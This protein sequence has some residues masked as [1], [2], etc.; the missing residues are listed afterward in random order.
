M[1]SRIDTR[2]GE[3]GPRRGPRQEEQRPGAD[4]AIAASLQQALAHHQ[5]GELARAELLYRAILAQQPNHVDSLHLL[6]VIEVQRRSFAAAVELIT[7]AI[8][9]DP[10]HSAF[11]SNLGMALQELKRHEDALAS[12]NRALAIKSDDAELLNSHGNV[13]RSLKRH[14][15]ALASYDRALEVRPD[16]VDALYN[17]GV[18]LQNLKRHEEALASYDHALAIKPDHAEAFYNRGN[19]LK[20]LSRHEEAL[21]SYERTLAIRPGYVEALNN[22]GNTLR[23]LKRYDEAVA[24][25][26]RALAIQPDYAG[27]LHN[28][29]T[30]LLEMRR[31]EDA[32]ESFA[33]LLEIAPDFDYALGNLF[34]SRLHGCNWTQY[35][36]N[37]ERIIRTLEEG[38]KADTPLPFLAVSSSAA[39]QLRC[40]RIWAADQYPSSPMPLPAGGRYGHDR[41]RLA[42][43]SADF[44]E[45][46]VSFLIAGLLEKHDRERFETIG[47]SLRPEDNSATGQ[48][49]KAAFSRFVDVSRRSDRDVAA[50]MRELEVDIAVDL[51]GFTADSRTAIFAHRSAPIQVSYLGF[52]ATMGAEYID[53][54][55]ADRFVIPEDRRACYAEKVVY[56]PDSFQANDDRRKIA[57]NIPARSEL[58]LPEAGF[59]F[60]SFNSSY[61]ISPPFFDV[62]MR[63]LGAVPGSALWLVGANVSV[64]NNLRVEAAKRGIEPRR[65]IFAPVLDYANH[66]ARF[67]LADL[68]LDSLPFN[69]GT[70]ASDA[71]WA[72]VPVLTCVG[73]AF[74]SRM[75]GSVLSAV[76][77]P[78]LI[79]HSL[80]E[81]EKLALKI[82]VTPAML[83]GLR[84]RLAASRITRPLF[85]TDRFR[86]HIES[87]YVTM[88]E[89]HR[90][91]EPP[92]SFA[93]QPAPW[94]PGTTTA[95][96]T[97][98][99]FAVQSTSEITLKKIGRN[100][101]FPCGS[102]KQHEDCCMRPE[103]TTV[104]RE[105]FGETS[106]TLHVPGSIQLALQHHQA[107]RLPHAEAIYRRVLQA[108]P[109]N[110]DAL[111][112]LGLIAHQA[113]ENKTAANLIGR[114]IRANP[115]NAIYYNNIGPVYVT[116][117]KVDEAIACYRKALSIQPDYAEAHNNLGVAL[118]AQDKR[119]EAIACYRKAL[120]LNPS[121]AEAHYNLGNALRDQGQRDEAITCYRRALALNPSYAEA[122]NNLGVALKAQDKRDEAIACYRKALAL[123]PSYA[124][125]HY[126][127]GNA[128][129][130]QGQRDA[131]IAC[132]QKAL[133]LN[134][135]YAEA[136][137]NLGVLYEGQGKLEEAMACYRKALSLNPYYAE[138][139][140]NLGVAL[141]AQDKRDEAIACYRKALA[142]NPSYAEAHYNLGNALRDQGH[143]NEAIACYRK[144][145]ALNANYAEACNNLGNVLR[146]QGQRDDAIACYEKALSLKPDFAAVHHALIY[147]ANQSAEDDG[148]TVFALCKRFAQ[149]FE[150]DGVRPA[151]RNE[152][153]PD[154]RIRVGYVSGDFR[155]HSVACFIEP[156][157]ASHDDRA[158][159]V[160]CYSNH[161]Q[162]DRVTAKL[163]AYAKHW[164]TIAGLADDEVVE[165]IQR[166]GIDILVDL[167]GH[168]S[169]T[170]LLVFAR[171]PA[172]VQVT[173]IG[174]PNTTGL[175]AMDYRLTHRYVDPVGMTEKYHT[176]TLIR[177]SFPGCFHPDADL[178]PVNELPA[179]TTGC[180][181]FSSFNNFQKI[182]PAVFALWSRILAMLPGTRLLMICPAYARGHV[183]KEFLSHGVGPERLILIDRLPLQDYLALHNKVEIAL[184]PFPYN[185]GTT[186]QFSL[187]M[188]IP[189]VTLAGKTPVSRVGLAMMAE[190]GLEEFVAKDEEEYAQIAFR[191]AHDLEA[192]ARIRRALRQR[193]QLAPFCNAEACTRELEAAYRHMWR[194][195]CAKR[196]DG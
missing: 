137:N 121:Y 38:K 118:K 154:R 10:A 8:A 91:G 169:H 136:H 30:A 59:V 50:L 116:L 55:I 119:D 107:G 195:W 72:G 28:R 34:H 77:L 4:S 98:S 78:E 132:Y 179:L 63:L 58:G 134:P 188:G 152:A 102:G 175:A 190:A 94:N 79:T 19:A 21:G 90:R 112:L 115:F 158:V 170:R 24:S 100:A 27:V 1:V 144:A 191:W 97:L 156:V 184:D 168:T 36:Q 48:R 73:E 84:A 109:N 196:A 49:V 22:R 130:D 164:R 65:L 126:N 140:N 64:Q 104:S 149:Q 35:A 43:V 146:D 123:N 26:D 147:L 89:R 23:D 122:H 93:V 178:P 163:M 153:S 114:A 141:K 194:A 110:P 6:G 151:H 108:E 174:L 171:K 46:A 67:R 7:R 33:R 29:G 99:E 129:R 74:A 183:S 86:R 14:E 60:C 96:G 120:A 85:A 13:L 101:P 131:A 155:Q 12:Y 162:T 51:M 185:G 128:L 161:R 95:G 45:H 177:L 69:A 31:H 111:H 135:S 157:L 187:W 44:R 70:T 180:L 159:D 186:T 82:A 181:T 40:A 11:H 76:G 105:R 25:Y 189:V 81:Y 173:W 172:P 106:A 142:L 37:V 41:I 9:I 2:D 3:D 92:E 56:L 68:F 88:W 20:D 66:L 150:K 61:K 80:E 57:D 193:M 32:A 53:Y 139:H 52:P 18:A 192:L 148:A 176:E 71:L 113:G 127:L 15:E 47:V 103:A 39:L 62:W 5:R 117:K 54:I 75:G 182:T 16:Y 124:E 160:F 17:R 42:Y 167:S 165:L 125:A 83:A 145:L 138:A 133:A 143:R 87:A 166:D